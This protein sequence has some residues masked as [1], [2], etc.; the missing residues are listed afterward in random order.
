MPSDFEPGLVKSVMPSVTIL[1]RIVPL[2]RLEPTM[3][4][5]FRFILNRMAET[6]CGVMRWTFEPLR[7][8]VTALAYPTTGWQR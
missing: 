7:A 5:E 6:L 1:P 8:L 4:R 2:P 3:R